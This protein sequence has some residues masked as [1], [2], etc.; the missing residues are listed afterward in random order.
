MDS[1]Q[2]LA[3]QNSLGSMWPQGTTGNNFVENDTGVLMGIKLNMSQQWADAV[4]KKD[5][6]LLGA[7]TMTSP[8]DKKLFFASA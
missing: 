2:S 8:A 4:A 7:S 3:V 5:G 6:R 1:V